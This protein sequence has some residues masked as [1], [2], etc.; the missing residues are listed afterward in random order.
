MVIGVKKSV[1]VSN[2][3]EFEKDFPN[4]KRTH[5]AEIPYKK[6]AFRVEQ[7]TLGV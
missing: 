2:E 5:N 1:F 7:N 4:L 3:D 6:S